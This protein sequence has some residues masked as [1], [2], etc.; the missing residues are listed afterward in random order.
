[1]GSDS[2]L[3]SGDCLTGENFQ[4]GEMSAGFLWGYMG[5]LPQGKFQGEEVWGNLSG[6]FWVIFPGEFVEK[7]ISEVWL[8]QRQI[9]FDQLH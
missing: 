8:T 3:A 1:M 2:Q 4:R 7:E 5:T 9:A 6:V